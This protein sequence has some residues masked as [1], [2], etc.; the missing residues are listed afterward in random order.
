MMGTL[1]PV[2]WGI[3]AAKVTA[4][5]VGHLEVAAVG[6][7]PIQEGLVEAQPVEVQGV[8]SALFLI[9]SKED[10]YNLK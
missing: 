2:Q 9:E 1:H 4:R 6:F 8:L 5:T 10:Y 7:I 3:S